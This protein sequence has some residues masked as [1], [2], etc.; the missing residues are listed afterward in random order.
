MRQ[1]LTDDITNNSL[2]ENFEN[3][4]AVNAKSVGNQIDRQLTRAIAVGVLGEEAQIRTQIKLENLEESLVRTT[5]SIQE[6]REDSANI[7]DDITETAISSTN[8]LSQLLGQ[9][10]SRLIELQ[11]KNIEIENQQ[12][13]IIAENL[14]QTIRLNQNLQYSNLNLANISQ[15]IESS[16]RSR[17]IKASAEAARLLRTTSQVD[18]SGRGK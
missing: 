14:G 3:N 18:L 7:L 11:L 1:S 2:S 12:S 16:N 8:P 13:K 10:Q 5:D 4:P 9:G 17:R 6:I 15:E